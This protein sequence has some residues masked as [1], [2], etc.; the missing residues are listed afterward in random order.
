M[1]MT[2]KAQS[3]A[4][5]DFLLAATAGTVL[6]PGLSSGETSRP[7]Q[8]SGYEYGLVGPDRSLKPTI[9]RTFP[10][11]DLANLYEI[12]D[13]I[14]R[15]NQPRMSFLESKWSNLEEWKQAA[16]PLF[17]QSLQY[18]PTPKP[19]SAEVISR[20]RRDG[21]TLEAVKIA[22]TAA[23][24]IPGW[25]LVPDKAR[26]PAP[27]IIALHDH[28]GNYLWGH[29]KIISSP[30]DPPALTQYR[31]HFYGRPYPEVLAR[32]GYVVLVI[33]GFYFG[34]RRLRVEE[35][36]VPSAP[37]SMRPA[38]EELSK[39]KPNT[40]AWFSAVNH[41]CGLY[42]D[43]TAKT[44]FAAGATWPGI[45]NWDDRRSVDYLTSRPEVD[46]KRIG[47]LGLS[48][49][50]L[51]TDYLAAADPRIKVACSV[52]WMTE[53]RPQLRNYLR[54]HT[55]MVYIPGLNGSLDL[56]DQAAMI[57]PGA[58]MVQQCLRDGLYPHD[59]QRASVKKLGEIYAKAGIPER[60]S[61]RF[62]DYGHS[63]RPD[64]QDDAFAWIE[65]WI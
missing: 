56:P 34:S 12:T 60:F 65:K 17:H 4:R 2:K 11:P 19:L 18:Q 57:A 9:D 45:L 13:W 27:G 51:R 40:R 15:E 46:P 41:L 25:V 23:Y 7:P 5:R 10:T 37:G 39:I 30:H 47:C 50:G 61:G 55:W 21:F 38:L 64:M 63:F 29:E 49:G 62:Y 48:L 58:F 24:S 20:E 35:I 14:S 43:L 22:A 3:I 42:E 32:K 36:D 52:G 1:V 44:I 6:Q 54:N 59:G 33:D 28:G 8:T 53:F 16:R 31:N 26:R